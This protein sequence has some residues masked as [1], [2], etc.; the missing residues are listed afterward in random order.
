MAGPRVV[1]W[2]VGNVIVRWNPRTLYSK[3]FPDEV[4]VCR[5][6]AGT[7]KRQRKL[8]WGMI[9]VG[10]FNDFEFHS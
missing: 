4:R 9:A 3:I 7:A 6:F 1:L 8:G 5:Y 2:D 10:G